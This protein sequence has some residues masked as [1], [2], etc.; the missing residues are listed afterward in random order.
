MAGMF[1]LARYTAPECPECPECPNPDDV[2]LTRISHEEALIAHNEYLRYAEAPAEPIQGYSIS[3]EQLKAMN[4]LKFI[5]E[6]QLAG[7]MMYFVPYPPAVVKGSQDEDDEED[8]GD[9][10]TGTVVV[11]VDADGNEIVESYFYTKPKQSG[12]CPIICDD[13]SP[14]RTE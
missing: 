3:M 10:G 13:A 4:Y 5:T 2:N 11:P 14:F 12:L 9:E 6:P 8:P 1:L 7:F